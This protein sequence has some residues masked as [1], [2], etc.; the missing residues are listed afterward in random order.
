[1]T[2]Y[3]VRGAGVSLPCLLI[4]GSPP[5]SIASASDPAG[6]SYAAATLQASN[7]GSSASPVSKAL[8]SSSKVRSSDTGV[9]G[10]REAGSLS[11]SLPPQPQ[12]SPKGKRKLDLNL[13]DRKPPSKP[14]AGPP[15]LKRPKCK[16]SGFLNSAETQAC[17]SKGKGWGS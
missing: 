7:A 17:V 2:G 5:P 12:E 16:Q 1:M 9:W 4:L 3:P 13:E 14:S 6:P 15:A 8:G 11:P 10:M